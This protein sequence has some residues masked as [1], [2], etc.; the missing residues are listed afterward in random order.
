MSVY[1]SWLKVKAVSLEQQAQF[2]DLLRS[3]NLNT[4]CENALCPNIGE[5]FVKKTATFLIMG[6]NCSRSCKFCAVQKGKLSALEPEEPHR[7]ANTVEQLGLGYVVITSVTRDDLTDGG[8]SHFASCIKNIKGN[9]VA[10]LIEVLVPDFKGSK[11]ALTTVV[12]AKPAVVN[13]NIE[14][15]PRLYPT[16][17]PEAYYE[18]SLHLLESVKKIDSKIITKSGLMLGLGETDG[19]VIQTMHD[20]N[21]VGCD[22]LTIGQYLS[23]STHHEPVYK[24]YT[25]DE[26]NYYAQL[27]LELGFK[28]VV[29]APLAR[30]SYR[31]WEAYLKATKLDNQL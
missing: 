30:S 15:V 8:A 16:I 21:V 25:P 1:P 29:S 23:P 27:G 26:Y 31:A 20:L 24:Y 9:N 19:E 4:V 17:R 10:T 13:H 3:A 18:R 22:I 11:S 14:T 7:L 6:E 2:E 5:C 12:Q 28:Y